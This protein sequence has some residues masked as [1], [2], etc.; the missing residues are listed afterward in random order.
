MVPYGKIDATAMG[1]P[2]MGLGIVKNVCVLFG[3]KL[4]PILLQHCNAVVVR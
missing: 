3:N 1:D 2:Y 4:T